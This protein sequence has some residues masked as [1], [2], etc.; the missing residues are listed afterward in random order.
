MKQINYQYFK[1]PIGEL[2]LGSFDEKLCM[3]DWRYR[4]MRNRIDSRI[5]NGLK[6]KFVESNDKLI[7]KS[8]H[9]LGE[10]FNYKRKIFSVPILM[11][12][13]E[14]QKSVWDRLIKIPYG[15]TL[16]YRQL[17]ESI[18]DYNSVRAVA[19]ANGANAI[20][21]IIP[22]HRVIAS[23]GKLA[24]YAGGLNAKQKLLNIENDLFNFA[25]NS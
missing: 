20:S 18:S 11:V 19:N 15:T 6:A 1:S 12:G 17:A 13:T 24:G 22:C 25:C 9:Q 5:E 7:E 3:C 23:N 21:I 8:K 2:I 4:K 16:S 10:Y 14:F